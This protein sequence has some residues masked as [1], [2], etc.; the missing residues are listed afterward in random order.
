MAK[1]ERE[2]SGIADELVRIAVGC[3]DYEDLRDDLDHA[4]NKIP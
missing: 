4:L 2:K 3:E 1:I